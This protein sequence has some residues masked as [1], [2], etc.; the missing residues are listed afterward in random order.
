[1]DVYQVGKYIG[2]RKAATTMGYVK[3]DQ[4]K[5]FEAVK[6]KTIEKNPFLTSAKTSGNEEE[7]CQ[8]KAPISLE[9]LQK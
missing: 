8:R 1:M 4:E 3:I 2:H 7:K 5:A 6:R 9:K